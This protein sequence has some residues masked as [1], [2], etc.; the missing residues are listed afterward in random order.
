MFIIYFYFRSRLA[1]LMQAKSDL[2]DLLASSSA[3][4]LEAA[5]A[6]LAQV[7]KEYEALHSQLDAANSG[8]KE[9]ADKAVF[10]GEIFETS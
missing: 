3:T 10:K 7:S 1:F 8:D 9:S 2:F 5:N 4:N 6:L